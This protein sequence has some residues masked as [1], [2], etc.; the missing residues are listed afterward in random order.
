MEASTERESRSVESI[1]GSQK[2]CATRHIICMRGVLFEFHHVCVQHLR[3][4]FV[5]STEVNFAP[6][7]AGRPK[8]FELV[9]ATV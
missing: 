6:R 7:F 2:Q 3:G 9:K 4:A 1:S 5:A 8:R